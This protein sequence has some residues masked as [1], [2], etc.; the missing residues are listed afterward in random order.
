MF[1]NSWK[2][3]K[4]WE[5]AGS[6]LVDGLNSEAVGLIGFEVRN[7]KFGLIGQHWVLLFAWWPPRFHSITA[8][9][10]QIY[11]K[12]IFILIILQY[13]LRLFFSFEDTYQIF[14]PW[15]EGVFHFNCAAWRV[16]GIEK[17]NLMFRTGMWG[18]EAKVRIEQAGEKSENVY[19]SFFLFH[20]RKLWA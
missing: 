2:M 7:A 1:E 11:H 12:L 10:F 19:E 14:D 13:F 20:S 18:I 4:P 17:S 9:K 8:E 16:T 3:E 5:G 15:S 6:T